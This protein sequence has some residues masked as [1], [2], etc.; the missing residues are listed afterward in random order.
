[1]GLFE[2]RWG[3]P[4][5]DGGSVRLPRL[6]GQG[7]ALE[8]ALTGRKIS[9]EESLK[10]G[11]CE[12]VVEHGKARAVAENTALEIARFPQE[13]VIEGYGRPIHEGFSSNTFRLTPKTYCNI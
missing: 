5:L 6:V 10:I 2:R 9:A 11:L 3:I 8:I 7:R 4:L 12:R 1:M 13:A